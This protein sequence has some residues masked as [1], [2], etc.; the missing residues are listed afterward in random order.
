MSYYETCDALILPSL[1]EAQPLVLLEA[2][3]AR[4]PIIGTNVIGVAD[5]LQEKGV[6]VE[7]TVEGIIEGIDRYYTDYDL[8]PALVE[9]AYESVEEF[10]WRYNLKKYE[11]LYEDVMEA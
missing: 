10:R 7:P 5:H 6:I 3:A 8:L 1:Y 11:A 4:I 2:M 9:R